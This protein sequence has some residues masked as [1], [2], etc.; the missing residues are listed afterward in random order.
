MVSESILSVMGANT[1]D[2]RARVL[3][4]CVDNPTLCC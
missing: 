2:V 1:L 3:E 4:V